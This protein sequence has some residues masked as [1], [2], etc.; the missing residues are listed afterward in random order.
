MAPDLKGTPLGLRTNDTRT[1]EIPYENSFVRL[2]S[3]EPNEPKPNEL[4]ASRSVAGRLIGSFDVIMA[5]KLRWAD[6]RCLNDRKGLPRSVGIDLIGTL[7]KS[8]L[9]PSKDDSYIKDLSQWD[10]TG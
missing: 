7:D 10:L 8:L 3:E 6:L 5:T 9:A 2:L 4:F 1:N